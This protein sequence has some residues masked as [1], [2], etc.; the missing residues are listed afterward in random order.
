[1]AA[2]VGALPDLHM[3]A[4][5]GTGAFIMRGAGCT[6]NDMWDQDIDKLVKL[7]A[8]NVLHLYLSNFIEKSRITRLPEQRIDL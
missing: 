4:L 8:S 2:P 3:L 5:F 6:I 1:M 7:F